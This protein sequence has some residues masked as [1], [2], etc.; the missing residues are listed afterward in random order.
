MRLYF[1]LGVVGGYLGGGLARE[2]V[3]RGALCATPCSPRLL[4]F[5][6]HGHG[7]DIAEHTAR[8]NIGHLLDMTFGDFG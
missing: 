7:S 6:G 3:T 4:V 5:R 1:R 2:R 8:G